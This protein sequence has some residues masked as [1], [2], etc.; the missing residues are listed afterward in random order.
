MQ[1]GPPLHR[2]ADVGGANMIIKLVQHGQSEVNAGVVNGT[3]IVEANV[4]LTDKGIGQ[5][6]KAG[7]AF[8]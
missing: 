1:A 7:I 3:K 6:Q 2:I 4:L 8:P 5:S